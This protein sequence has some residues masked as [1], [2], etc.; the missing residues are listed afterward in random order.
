MFS[1][2]I[3]AESLPAKMIISTFDYEH[4]LGWQIFFVKR[5]KKKQLDYG[6]KTLHAN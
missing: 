5:V 3:Y 2:A 4:R 1:D 6:K